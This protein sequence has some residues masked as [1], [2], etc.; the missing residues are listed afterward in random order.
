ME[1]RSQNTYTDEEIQKMVEEIL[2]EL[3]LDVKEAV[4]DVLIHIEDLPTSELRKGTRLPRTM[5]GLYVGTPISRQHSIGGFSF[6]PQIFLFRKNIERFGGSRH[7]LRFAL[8]ETLLHEIGHHLGLSESQVR[9][10]DRW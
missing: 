9:E 8:R 4:K 5:L 6:P 7:D 2:D 10:L 1:E 3:P